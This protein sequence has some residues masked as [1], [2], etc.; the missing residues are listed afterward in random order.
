[1]CVCV[2]HRNYQFASDKLREVNDYLQLQILVTN[3]PAQIYCV[4]HNLQIDRMRISVSMKRTV[5]L[6]YNIW[7]AVNLIIH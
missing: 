3:H 2:T 6:P 5:S 1:M 7:H 4:Y